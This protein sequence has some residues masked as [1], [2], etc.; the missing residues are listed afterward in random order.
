[1]ITTVMQNN[2]IEIPEEI[3]RHFGIKPGHCLD[4]QPGE[5]KDEIRIRIVSDRGELARR[6]MGAGRCYSPERDSVAE[7]IAERSAEG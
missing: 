3:V 5:D 4:W 6:I 2:R 1:M 7:L